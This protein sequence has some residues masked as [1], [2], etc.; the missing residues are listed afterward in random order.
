MTPHLAD[1]PVLETERLTLRAPGPQDWEACAAFL[2]SGRA[3][4][5][6]GPHTRPSAWRSFAHLVGHWA[7]RGHGMFAFCLKGRD[8]VIGVAGPQYPEGW[9]E[10]EI[11]WSIWSEA[12][13]GRGYVSEAARA[14]RRWAF[15]TLGWQTCVSYIDPANTRSIALAERLGCT[16]DPEAV[17][18]DLPDWEGTLVYRHPNRVETA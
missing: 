9:A 16:L 13:E 18:P 5:I 8:V 1:T 4:Y 12:N 2:T 14:T 11:G 3:R 17:V 10:P 15:D 7:L 6:D